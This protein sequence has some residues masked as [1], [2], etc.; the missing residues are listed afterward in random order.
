MFSVNRKVEY[1]SAGHSTNDIG[2]NDSL[3][4][5]SKTLGICNRCTKEHFIHEFET[6]STGNVDIDII[7]RET[8][9]TKEWGIQWVPYGDLDDVQQI[10][11]GEY[12]SVCSA[13]IRGGVKYW[14]DFVKQDW[15]RDIV[16]SK[17]ALKELKAPK[18]SAYDIAEILSVVCL[19]YY[20]IYI[21]FFLM[22]SKLNLFIMFHITLS[23]IRSVILIASFSS[24]GYR[25]TPL[26]ITTF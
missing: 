19:N 15:E 13:T 16:G 4:H 2:Y 11:D 12:G 25:E 26:H 21:P 14:W 18:Y 10:A 1:C 3:N 20:I 7:L 23:I 17:V 9:M 22:Q 24:S 8:Q 6:W 5:I